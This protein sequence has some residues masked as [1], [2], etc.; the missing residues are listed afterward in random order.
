MAVLL[1]FL[2]PKVYTTETPVAVDTN[3]WASKLKLE[4][5]LVFLRQPSQHNVGR[6]G[7]LKQQRCKHLKSHLV[8]KYL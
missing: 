3:C 2:A 4:S 7:T 5:A 6:W 1:K 8:D